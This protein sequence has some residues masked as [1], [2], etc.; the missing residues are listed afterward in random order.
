MSN[1]THAIKGTKITKTKDRPKS[2]YKT[3]QEIQNKNTKVKNKNI[4]C[5]KQKQRQIF[6]MLKYENLNMKRP[7]Q[8]YGS[9]S[10]LKMVLNI[11]KVMGVVPLFKPF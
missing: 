11:L 4:K 6:I 3:Q 5:A 2:N 10:Y 9:R 1:M 8:G 7:K